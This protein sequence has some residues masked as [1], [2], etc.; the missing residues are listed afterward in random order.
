MQY[1]NTLPSDEES[2]YYA[3]HLDFRADSYLLPFVSDDDL[4]AVLP[5]CP[6][7]TSARLNGIH[8]L[9][10]RTLI[11]LASH[12]DELTHLDVSGCADVTD[13]GLKAIAT[14]ATSLRALSISRVFS[15]TDAAIG[16][17]VRGLPHLE[18]LDMDML[19]LVTALSTRDVWTYGKKLRRWSL[20]GCKNVTDSGFPWTPTRDILEVAQGTRSQDRDR[21]RSWMETLPPLVLPPIYKLG[22]LRFLD[23]SHCARVTDAAVFGLVAHAPR[24]AHLN[25]SGCI[26][27]GNGAMYRLCELG[28]HLVEI[29]VAGLDEVTDA[30]MYALAS[31][32][33]RLR[34]VDISC[35]CPP[36]PIRIM[37]IIATGANI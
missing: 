22:D 24:I 33:P 27:I 31:A 26:K 4:A 32:C 21:Y 13:L 8:D 23:L 37:P 35:Q 18:E 34:S 30:G 15:T 2:C 6:H 20:A 28:E 19:P 17:L 25:L 16:A 29:D 3:E 1:V 11:L 10:S 14:Y 9:S 12:A 5:H 7:V 36:S